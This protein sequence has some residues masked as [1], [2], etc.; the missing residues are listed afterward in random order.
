MT[1]Q[2]VAELL[3]RIDQRVGNV[4]K[5]IDEM[6]KQRRCYTNTEKIRSIER[7][8]WTAL[9]ASVAAMVKSFWPMGGS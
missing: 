5:T 8:V 7:I 9:C 2:E 3:V 6:N 4:E 1:D